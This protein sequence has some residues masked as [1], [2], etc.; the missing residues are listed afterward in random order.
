VIKS[1]DD[2]AVW[3]H[4][5][6]RAKNSLTAA[7]AKVVEERFQAR[8]STIGDGQGSEESWD[9]LGPANKPERLASGERP[10]PVVDQG[11]VSTGQPDVGARPKTAANARKRARSSSVR[12]LGK[13][14]RL[15]DKNHRRFV[16]RQPCLVCGRVPSDPHHLTFTQPRA[17]GRRVSDEFMVPV[18]RVHHRELHRSGDEAAWWRKLN[19]DPLPVA[20]RLWQRSRTDGELAPQPKPAAQGAAS[21]RASASGDRGAGY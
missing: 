9:D 8:L 4:R 18:C 2:A 20:L 16:L 1:A 13:T 5:N 15:R 17:L 7:D 10:R 3:A 6:M 21:A 12:A 19:I 14:V 11:A